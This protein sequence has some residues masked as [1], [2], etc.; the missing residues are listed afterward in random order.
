MEEKSHVGMT[1][2]WI[3]QEGA[4]ILLDTRLRKTLTKEMGSRPDI[5]CSECE[6]QS[7]DN[8][9]IWLIAIRDGERPEP[10]EYFN[11]YRTGAIV[12][13]KK[14]ALKDIFKETLNAE[15][16]AKAI[17]NVDRNIYFYLEDTVWVNYGLP[18][19]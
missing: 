9:A 15:T 6:K 7:K 14:A 13:I 17:E 4:E 16:S 19:E 2:C 12:L 1:Q 18:T 5:T 3:C 8:D 10:N 11:P